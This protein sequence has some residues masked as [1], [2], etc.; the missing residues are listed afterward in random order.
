MNRFYVIGFVLLTV[1]LASGCTGD[2]E[3]G[4]TGDDDTGDDDDTVSLP[5]DVPPY[6]TFF[7]GRA[8]FVYLDY[9]ETYQDSHWESMSPYL[10]FS[11]Q[12]FDEEAN[13]G[14]M[15]VLDPLESPD[16]CYLVYRE[17]SIAPHSVT[18]WPETLT[19]SAGGLTC[20]IEPN[21]PIDPMSTWNWNET[22]DTELLT[23]PQWGEPYTITITGD[24]VP[25]IV[26]DPAF[27]FPVE[28]LGDV[29]PT[30]N[31]DTP[32]PLGEITFTWEG[33][34]EDWIQIYIHAYGEDLHMGSIGCWVLD[35]GEFTVPADLIEQ[36]PYPTTHDLS[37]DIYRGTRRGIE[38]S[39][40]EW[41]YLS[42]SIRAGGVLRWE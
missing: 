24:E 12:T 28:F 25:A 6:G 31:E 26:A 27:T 23:E 42:A 20:V 18:I 1:P 35:D 21:D 30:L 13:T 3:I 19:I 14:T 2:G 15:T 39:G 17:G 36:L 7:V 37:V 38:I 34:S 8:G 9:T 29:T 16:D 33:T 5:G 10:Y 4:D 32:I 22:G 41:V 40:D 11:E